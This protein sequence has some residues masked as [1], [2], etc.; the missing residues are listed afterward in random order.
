MIIIEGG[1][2][3]GKTRV[4]EELGRQHELSSYW[5]RHQTKPPPGTDFFGCYVDMAMRCGIFDRFHMSEV[6]YATIRGEDPGVTPFKYWLVDGHLR[7]LGAFTVVLVSDDELMRQRLQQL[8]DREE[9]YDEQQI[10]DV[11]RA[12]RRMVD[13]GFLGYENLDCDVVYELTI[14]K[15]YVTDEDVRSITQMYCQKQSLLEEAFDDVTQA[16]PRTNR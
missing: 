1:D 14:E 13:G 11:N 4:C 15:P 6:A 10:M 3:V 7:S 5:Y 16:G 9:M 8:Q 12:F 2:M